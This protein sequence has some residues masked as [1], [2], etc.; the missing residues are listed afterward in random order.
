[1]IK[2]LALSAVATVALA[3]DTTW[4]ITIGPGFWNDGMYLNQS[5]SADNSTLNSTGDAPARPN[6]T[7]NI[8]DY[9]NGNLSWIF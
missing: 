1:M 8:S 4:N 9:L 2:A 6:M 7:T 5:G 3:V